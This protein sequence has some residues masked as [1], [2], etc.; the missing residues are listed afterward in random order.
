MTSLTR[1]RALLLAGFAAVGLLAYARVL[2]TSFLSDDWNIV[3]AVHRNG[4][5]GVF[6]GHSRMFLRPLMSVSIRFDYV[7]YGLEPLGFHLTNVLLHVLCA[8]L[9]YAVGNKLLGSRVGLWSGLLFLV[10]PSHTEAVSWIAGRNDVLCTFFSLLS[11]LTYLSYV[12]SRRVRHLCGSLAFLALALLSKEAALG[13]PAVIAAHLVISRPVPRRRA[14][15]VLTLYAGLV[16]LYFLLRYVIL[17]VFVSEYAQLHI[18]PRGVVRFL[19]RGVAR[20]LVPPLHDRP[21]ASAL[22]ALALG[23]LGVFLYRRL[24]SCSK[25]ERRSI[26]RR[27]GFPSVA[28]IASAAP[29]L[30]LALSMVDT[31]GDRFLYLPSAFG[32]LALAYMLS[33]IVPQPRRFAICAGAVAAV[34]LAALLSLNENWRTAS[35]LARRTLT[36]TAQADLPPRTLFLTVPDNYRGAYVFRNGL[37]AALRLTG[38]GGELESCH[39][40][41]SITLRSQR[42]SIDIERRGARFTVSVEHPGIHLY[43][44]PGLGWPSRLGTLSEVS[45]HGF[46]FDMNPAARDVGVYFWSEGAIHRYPGR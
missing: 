33:V 13:V 35:E 26:G 41:S 21:L 28:F 6:T 43:A 4:A 32:C 18:S 46:V 31:Q 5:F 19:R 17:G 10:H 25:E 24:R 45:T 27:L 38:I 14:V 2:N 40:L 22:A 23:L 11:F 29:V 42:E 8:F 16:M 37:W 12:E 30:P 39:R 7:L 9:V 15:S 3:G 36:Q 44:D 1:R 34:F 20:M